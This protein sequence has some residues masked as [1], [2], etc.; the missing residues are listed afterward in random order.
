MKTFLLIIFLLFTPFA[1][2]SKNDL[3]VVTEDWPPFIVTGKNISGIVTEN[4]REI[5][6]YTDIKYSM[7]VY[8]WARSFQLATSKPNVLIYSI[9][10]TKQR[11]NQFNWF[12]PIFESTPIHAYKL[13]SN[14]ININTLESLKKSVVGVMRGDHSYNY[15]LQQ[16]FQEGVNLDLSSNEE[17]N[18][19]KLIKGRVDVVL[20]AKESLIYRLKALGVKDLNMVPGLEMGQGKSV[21]HCMA[22]SLGTKPETIEKIKQG[23]KQWQKSKEGL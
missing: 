11:E 16:G 9:Y 13:A 5:L 14:D 20:L 23:F 10:R 1:Q 4:I 7:N 15:L 21:E 17:V 6:S 22:L 12:C 18:L 8:P 3:E 19:R 2:A